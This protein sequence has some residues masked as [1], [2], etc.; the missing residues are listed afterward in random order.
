[1]PLIDLGGIR[2]HYQQKGQGPDVVLLHAVTSNLSVWLFINLLEILATEFRVTAYDLRGHG[3]SDVPPS[4]YTSAD[5]AED[6][7]RLHAA[8]GL[9][10]ALLVGHSFGAVVAVHAA[11]LYPEMVRGLILSDP[12]F[13]GLAHLEP[14]LAGVE[15]WREVRQAL[16]GAGADLGEEVD[17]TRL[18][19]VAA[20]LTAVQKDRMSQQMG[21]AALRWLSQLSRLAPTTCGRDVFAE[22]GLT[23]ERIGQ[24]RQPV[25][26]LYDEHTSFQATRRFLEENVP[27][28]RVEIVPS[29]RHLAPLENSAGFV[30]LVQTHLRSL[31]GARPDGTNTPH[32]RSRERES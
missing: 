10:P 28:C 12:F 6:L 15:V 13:P 2:F 19:C 31:A 24:V 27:H 17:F 16:V 11:L 14:N 21:P 30:H 25:V 3:A 1:M 26:A 4:G 7:R 23:A 20:E 8:L 9:G 22:A 29:A 32:P 18:F 5:M